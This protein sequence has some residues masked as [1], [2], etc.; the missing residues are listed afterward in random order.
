MSAVTLLNPYQMIGTDVKGM[1]TAEALKHAGLSG[2][3]Q[4]LVTPMIYDDSTTTIDEDGHVKVA[5][6]EAGGLRVNVADLP[7]GTAVL[8]AVT[9][10]YEPIQLEDAFTPLLDGFG[11]AGLTP[12]ILGAYDNGR[13]AFILFDVPNGTAA[14]GGDDVT[15]SLL[16]AKRNDGKGGIL[17]Y[18]TAERVRCA[19]QI[20]GLIH[21]TEAAIRVRHTRNAD[22]FIVQQAERLLGITQDWN[23]LLTTAIEDLQKV[24]VTKKDFVTN[25]VPKVL[26]PQPSEEGRSLSIWDR[27][28]DEIVSTWDGPV[29]VQE[30]NAW[31]ALNT[32]TEWEQH[33][34]TSDELRMATAVLKGSQPYTARALALL[35]A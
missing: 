15:C 30:N 3:N 27:K 16:V 28:F 29:A 23:T 33:H 1:T 22:P 4:R 5:L 12:S 13:A 20:N 8:G 2:W 35:T 19:N 14:I 32:F 21:G 18:P 34:R 9:K 7:G 31:R 6:I 11:E 17:S 25:I 26:G 10:A 24:E